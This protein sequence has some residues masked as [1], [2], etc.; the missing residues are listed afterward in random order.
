MVVKIKAK[1]IKIIDD[2]SIPD[3][4]GVEKENKE[5]KF[6]ISTDT[7]IIRVSK[8]IKILTVDESKEAEEEENE[9]ADPIK[10]KPKPLDPII[11]VPIKDKEVVKDGTA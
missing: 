11:E 7:V 8:S 4:G 1:R 10:E 5:D 6:T 2:N 9:Q 3:P